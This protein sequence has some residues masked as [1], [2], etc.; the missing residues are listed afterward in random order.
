[1]TEILTVSQFW[2]NIAGPH[3]SQ[4]IY[5]IEKKAKLRIEITLF[6]AFKVLK[7]IDRERKNDYS[8]PTRL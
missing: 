3:N 1:M 7:Y 6:K 4:V 2:F 5:I 8:P